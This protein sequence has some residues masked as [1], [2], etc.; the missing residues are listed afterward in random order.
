MVDSFFA[1]TQL[2]RTCASVAGQ[3]A[4]GP[5]RGADLPLGAI[6]GVCAASAWK[7]TLFASIAPHIPTNKAGSTV[8]S[9]N[10]QPMLPTLRT[11]ALR[12]WLADRRPTRTALGVLAR[13]AHI[14]TVDRQ[15]SIG[16]EV[17][18][19]R[20]HALVLPIA[21]GVTARNTERQTIGVEL[22]GPGNAST[23]ALIVVD[24]STA[25]AV[26]A[27]IVVQ[28]WDAPID[29]RPCLT[30][31]PRHAIDGGEAPWRCA[32]AAADRE[33]AGVVRVRT[34]A[35]SRAG[36]ASDR[37]AASDG[38]AARR[39]THLASPAWALRVA[40]RGLGRA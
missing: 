24:V 4:T 16:A 36:P 17:G 8:A 37:K 25:V 15:P 35:V 31:V 3:T 18:V 30:S 39:E 21:I 34:V 22:A 40:N 29:T 38:L 33:I 7:N 20:G 5:G 23:K 26:R 2:L 10:A 27:V 11:R 9:V 28:T 32:K 6:G 19:L 1:T 13:F 14:A 12:L